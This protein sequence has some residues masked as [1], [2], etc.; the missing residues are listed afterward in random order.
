MSELARSGLTRDEG[1]LYAVGRI[2]LF[3]PTG[4]PLVPSEGFD[5]L[6]RLL[7]AGGVTR[8]AIANPEHAPYGQ[9]AEAALRKR[10]SGT[11]S[12][13]A[14]CSATTSRRRRSS[15][16][17]QCRGRASS[18]TRWPWRR[19]SAARGTLRAH[20][21]ERP[22]AAAP[23]DGAAQDAPDRWP[24]ASTTIFRQPAARAVFRAL[25]LR[26]AAITPPDGLDRPSA[27]R[28]GSAWQLAAASASRRVAGSPAGHAPLSRQGAR[29]SAWSTCRWC[30]RPRCWASTCWCSS[31][32]A[33]RSER[34]FERCLG[35]ALAV[36][37]P[38]PA[39]A[40]AIANMP[41]VVQPIQRAFEAVPA[42]VREA[43]AC[44]G[45][46][47]WQRFLRIEGPLA[48]PGILTAAILAFAHTLGEFGVVLMVGGNLPGET[49]T[50]SIAIY[51]RM[52]AFDDRGAGMMAATLLAFAVAALVTT[53]MLSDGVWGI[54]A[55]RAPSVA[56][57]TGA[58]RS[59][60]TSLSVRSG[61]GRSRSLA[62]RAAARRRP[63]GHRRTVRAAP[64][65]TCG[66]GATTWLDTGG[67][68]AC[69]SAPA[70]RRVRVSGLRALPAPDSAR[71]RDGGAR[72]STSA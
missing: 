71:Q 58:A 19:T 24:R 29:R 23:A 63:A 26:A 18:P 56:L 16:Y 33:R 57:R 67:G 41:F 25:R 44:C 11:R 28:S 66:S 48:W 61:R 51:D 65:A 3:A 53:T 42:D 39:L 9:A 35:H 46:S 55:D 40:S 70:S 52:Q 31:A 59:R 17:G 43:A 10:G 60:S 1:A 50:L 6:R 69:P 38:R 64:G 7:A 15:P 5:G 49:R 54:V 45:L 27:C 68:S 30:C 22:R 21:R 47:P 20:P 4:S 32:P 34:P 8:F 13:R 12:S 72:A 62:R 36:L 2:V 14:S 37:V